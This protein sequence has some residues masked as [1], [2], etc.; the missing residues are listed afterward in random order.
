MKETISSSTCFLS[1]SF[2]VFTYS[3][4]ILGSCKQCEFR[5][6]FLCRTEWESRCYS[7]RQYSNDNMHCSC[8]RF[9]SS[10]ET[11]SLV[12][13]SWD[14]MH[15]WKHKQGLFQCGYCH[16]VRVSVTECKICDGRRCDKCY[17][18]GWY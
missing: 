4:L 10:F 15:D 9:D 8:P 18:R 17:Q 2:V 13:Q 14:R 5:F 3:A 12:C 16:N 6:C 1:P 7:R 11:R